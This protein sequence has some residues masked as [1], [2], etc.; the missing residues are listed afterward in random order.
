MKQRPKFKTTEVF[1]NNSEDIENEYPEGIEMR[2]SS[3]YTNDVRTEINLQEGDTL[4][5]LSIR[6]Q[7]P[8]AEL[9]RLNNLHRENEIFARRTIKVPFRFFSIPTVHKSGD[10]SPNNSS[11]KKSVDANILKEKLSSVTTGNL[12][13]GRSDDKQATN[14][15][16]IIFNTTIINKNPEEEHFDEC[17]MD[18]D[19]EIQL[20]P[21]EDQT[22]EEIVVSSELSCNGADWGLSWPIILGIILILA[23][24]VPLIYIFYIAEHPEKYHQHNT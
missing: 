19:E 6:Y 23:F 10:N 24:V 20:L 5:S 22:P 13:L 16:K 1:K 3:T 11:A 15:N 7:C 2:I 21:K 14:L 4:Q 8:V 17:V 12:L 9:K 18:D